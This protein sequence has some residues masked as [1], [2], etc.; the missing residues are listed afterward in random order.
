MQTHFSCRSINCAFRKGAIVSHGQIGQT[1]A[2]F[3]RPTVLI[4]LLNL[5]RHCSYFGTVLIFAGR[6]AFSISSGSVKVRKY[7]LNYSVQFRFAL[8]NFEQY[9]S[10]LVKVRQK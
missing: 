6:A 2:Y 4:S 9:A 7:Y 3:S 8:C 10:G 5:F 1:D